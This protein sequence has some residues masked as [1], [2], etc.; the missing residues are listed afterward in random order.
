M[1]L[2]VRSETWA[3]PV[4]EVD[5]EDAEHPD[6][7][8]DAEDDGA[9]FFEE[10]LAAV[11][12]AQGERAHGGP[13]VLGQLEDE[14]RG[15][16][17]HDG[18]VEQLGG[19]ERGEEAEGV[20]AE[21]DQRAQADDA[22]E[23]HAVGDEG[24]DDEGV[25]GQARGAGHE[26]RDEDGGDA[27]ALVLDGARGHDGGDGAGVGG[28]QRD[29][30]FAVEADGAH[31]A[32]GDERGAGEVAGV[33]EDADEEEEQKDL[34]EE[35]EDGLDAVPEAVAQEEAQPVVG[36]QQRGVGAGVGEEVAEAVGE[37]LAEREDDLEDSEDDGE[38]DER[39]GD[40][41]EQDASRGGAS[42]GRRRGI[43]SWCARRPAW[44]SVRQDAGRLQH[45]E[46]HGAEVVCEAWCRPGGGSRG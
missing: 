29:E 15:V 35:D 1:T 10:E 4:G 34:R 20:E 14:G 39:A 24:R 11:V 43:G 9:G 40:A 3:V 13:A 41:V 25:D 2:A 27:L 32:V 18:G 6:E 7:E 22:A 28:E 26:R 23:E 42:R 5:G 31:D 44:P 46:L 38:E 30:G 12:E 8:G 33:F 17:L 45:G 36:K 16:G 37:R 21:H 19:D